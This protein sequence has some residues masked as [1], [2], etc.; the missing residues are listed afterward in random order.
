M[1]KTL[2]ITGVLAALATVACVVLLA[3]FGLKEDSAIEKILNAPSVVDIFKKQATKIKTAQDQV[4]PLVKWAKTFAL[5]INPPAPKIPAPPK[6]STVARKKT[7]KKE[8]KKPKVQVSAKFDLIATCRYEDQPEKS[9]A[10]LDMPAKGLEWFRVGDEVNHLIIHQINDGSI[11]LYKNGKKNSS[12]IMPV[13][14]KKSLLKADN[15]TPTEASQA[16]P[17][18]TTPAAFL[19]K[20]LAGKKDQTDQ[21]TATSMDPVAP[22]TAPTRRSVPA[23]FARSQEP[24]TKQRKDSLE[25]SIS[26]IKRIMSRSK[27]SQEEEEEGKETNETWNRL[28]KTLEKEKQDSNSDQ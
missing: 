16:T 9:M 22:D 27:G 3:L 1:I 10:L 20:I 24:D 11:E 28:L 21:T 26:N 8:I 6:K 5:R 2:K 23:Q 7:Q 18:E 13:I 14:K 19:A 12:L 4:S 17:P 25:K 15:N